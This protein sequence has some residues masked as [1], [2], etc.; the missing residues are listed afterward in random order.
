MLWI[1]ANLTEWEWELLLGERLPSLAQGTRHKVKNDTNC[2][3]FDHMVFHTSDFS[4]EYFPFEFKFHFMRKKKSHVHCLYYL[5]RNFISRSFWWD[6]FSSGEHVPLLWCVRDL[7]QC[8]NF[9][10]FH[11]KF[12][13]DLIY[14]PQ[15]SE[16]FSG[17]RMFTR[18]FR[19]TCDFFPIWK[20]RRLRF[21]IRFLT[22]G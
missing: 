20:N 8:M 5:N 14:C 4:T 16:V 17:W 21:G 7:W 6:F 2:W 22:N 10:F 19:F 15:R 13:N 12:S 18:F 3:A 1:A 9:A 11:N